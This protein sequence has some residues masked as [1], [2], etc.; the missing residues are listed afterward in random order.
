LNRLADDSGRWKRIYA[1]GTDVCLE[2]IESADALL[3]IADS[4]ISILYA[5]IPTVQKILFQPNRPATQL[6]RLLGT[7]VG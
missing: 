2:E 6:R 5:V 4:A 1:S 3:G 7:C